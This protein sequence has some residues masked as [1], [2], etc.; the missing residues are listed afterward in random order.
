M[1]ARVTAAS[2]PPAEVA[3]VRS[4][5]ALSPTVAGGIRAIGGAVLQPSLVRESAFVAVASVRAVLVVVVR[6]A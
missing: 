5:R 1:A 3:V 4:V 6:V 2:S